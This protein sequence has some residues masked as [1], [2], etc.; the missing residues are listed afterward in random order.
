MATLLF[1]H[2]TGV[3]GQA[4]D[5]TFYAVSSN[6]SANRMNVRVLSCSWGEAVGVQAPTTLNSLPVPH[7]R[8]DVTGI[9]VAPNETASELRWS[10]LYLDPLY[11]VR[12]YAAIA[13]MRDDD[14]LGGS[15]RA[16]RVTEDLLANSSLRNLQASRTGIEQAGHFTKDL[17]PEA[18]KL[19]EEGGLLENALTSWPLEDVERRR[20]VLA[21][22]I[23][24]AW[25]CV[26][27]Q[28]GLPALD[29]ELRDSL[30]ADITVALGGATK[31][32]KDE[33]LGTLIGLS[34]YAAST[35]F[36]PA[37][38]RNRGALTEVHLEKTN[39]VLLYQTARGG[40]AIREFIANSI[41]SCEKPV[42][43]LAHSLGGIA[44]AELLVEDHSIQVE[45][46]ITCGTQVSFLAESDTLAILRRGMA[47]PE[48][49]PKWLNAFDPSDLL[50]YPAEGVFGRRVEDLE[51]RSR[52]PFPWCHGSYWTS[53]TLW[54]RIGE[55]LA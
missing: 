25:C 26:A 7:Q 54:Q 4:F 3:R 33:L 5:K 11:E 22:A 37:I 46:L 52:Q 29:G 53:R 24:A 21:R 50:S 41:R 39:D 19:L 51:L 47:L 16:G 6:V 44:C 14:G 18:L 32:I 20:P 43:V 45:G 49:F 28:R 9:D 55:F 12:T 15:D 36:G 10:L 48:T 23:V 1:V 35:L 13:P 30:Y 8:T 34:G 40:R 27:A 38:R 2:G 31:G 42:F 17:L